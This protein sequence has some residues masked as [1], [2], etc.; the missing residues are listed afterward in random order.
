MAEVRS[1][2]GVPAVADFSGIGAPSPGTPI[3]VDQNTGD[4]YVLIAGVVVHVA[5]PIP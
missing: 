5:A 4:L 1:H 3:I 2:D